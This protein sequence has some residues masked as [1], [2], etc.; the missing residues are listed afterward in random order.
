MI[1]IRVLCQ[2]IEFMCRFEFTF[3]LLSAAFE[4]EEEIGLFLPDFESDSLALWNM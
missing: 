3:A 1:R 2:R 4:V